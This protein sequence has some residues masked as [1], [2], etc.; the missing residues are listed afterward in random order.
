MRLRH[1]KARAFATAA[2]HRAP[3]VGAKAPFVSAQAQGGR[4][5]GHKENFAGSAVRAKRL[6]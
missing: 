1:N 5:L 2:A 4:S 6:Y 3:G